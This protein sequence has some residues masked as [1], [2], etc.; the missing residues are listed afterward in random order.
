M[1]VGTNATVKALCVNQVEECQAQ[2]ILCNAYHLYLRPGHSLV[3]KAGGLHKFM[4]WEKPILTDSGGFQVFSLNALNKINDQG[5]WFKDHRS[6]KEHFVGPDQSMEIQNSLGADIIM[7]FDE[8]VKNPA[9]YDEAKLSMNRTHRWLERCVERHE[10]ADSQGLFGIVQGS[11]YEDLRRQSAQAVSSF[12]L[13]GFAI[14]GV[15]VG[16]DRET[17]ERIVL[18]TAPLLP[19]NKPRYLMGVGTPWDIAYA[20]RCGIDMFDCVLPTRLA[21][22][23]AAFTSKGRVSLRN[24]RFTEDFQ[25]LEPGCQ[26]F[27]CRNHTRAYLSHLIRLKEMTGATLLSIHNIYFLNRQAAAGRQAILDG[28]FRQFFEETQSFFSTSLTS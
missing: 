7:A 13:P 14:G 12:D 27:T 4:S 15:A 3:A 25:A 20:I 10:R 28:R 23:G 11:V 24:A 1:P 8:C 9:T 16:E 6:G 18:F 22:H 26:C 2:I 21:R 17:I 5:V 19:T